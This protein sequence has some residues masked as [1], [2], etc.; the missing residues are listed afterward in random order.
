LKYEALEISE[1]EG[2]F[3]RK[4][5]YTIIWGPMKARYLHITTAVGCSFESKLAYLYITVAVGSFES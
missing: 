4:I 5:V 3:E 1:V 2:Y